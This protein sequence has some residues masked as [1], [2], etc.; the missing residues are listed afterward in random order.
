M[1][2]P[3]YLSHEDHACDRGL[4]DGCQRRTGTAAEQQRGMLVIEAHQPPDVRAYRRARQ[5]DRRL[6]PHR[7]AE[8]D[9]VVAPPTID[10]QQLCPGMREL[11]LD[12]A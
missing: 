12:M 7:T 1:I 4:E 9:G 6:G 3:Q 10:V 8:P 11:R 5:Y 2:E